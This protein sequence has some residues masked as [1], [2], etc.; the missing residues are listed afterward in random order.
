MTG[1]HELFGVA[2]KA[3]LSSQYKKGYLEDKNIIISQSLWD[4]YSIII[5]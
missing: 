1:E 2:K 3:D 4:I 5:P